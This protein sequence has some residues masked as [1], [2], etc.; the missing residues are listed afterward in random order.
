MH[1][2]KSS[3]TTTTTTTTTT[4]VDCYLRNKNQHHN[5]CGSNK[6]A[7]TRQHTEQV[8]S[9]AHKNVEDEDDHKN[10]TADISCQDN[11]SVVIQSFHFDFSSFKS[12]HNCSKM[13]KNLVAIQHPKCNI[14]GKGVA[15]VYE[16]S[17][18]HHHN[19]SVSN[20]T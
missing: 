19:L 14:T 1:T 17:I 9:I 13:K 20:T 4:A 18:L 16:E 11:L 6:E 5:H 2:Q 3:S 7:E 15:C 12:H 10:K 8:N